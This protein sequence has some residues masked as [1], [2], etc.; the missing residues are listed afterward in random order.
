MGMKHWSALA[1]TCLA[2]AAAAD[3]AGPRIQRIVVGDAAAK[4]LDPAVE[5]GSL[6]VDAKRA[7]Y[8]LRHAKPSIEH[9]YRQA[10]E[11]GSCSASVTVRY[12]DGEQVRL[13]IDDGTGWGTAVQNQ[14]TTYLYCDRCEDV[15]EPDFDFKE[16]SR[17]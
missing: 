17:P 13:T 12:H 14:A 1:L 2:T 4:S 16:G 9:N 3:V 11:R 5:C 10:Y 6:R 8:F 7:R 15:L